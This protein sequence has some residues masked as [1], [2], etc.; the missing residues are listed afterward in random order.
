MLTD[1]T[2]ILL[3]RTGLDEQLLALNASDDLQPQEIMD[4]DLSLSIH[5]LL[6]ANP[7]FTAKHSP[8]RL[9]YF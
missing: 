8:K 4:T 7:T 1:G 9:T 5:V 2:L 6:P 3:A